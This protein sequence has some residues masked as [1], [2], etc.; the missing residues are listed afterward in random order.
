MLTVLAKEATIFT[1][2]RPSVGRNEV[3]NDYYARVISVWMDMGGQLKKTRNAM[4]AGG[5]QVPGGGDPW[6][7]PYQ[8][9]NFADT[10][11]KGAMRKD[12]FLV[13]INSYFDLYSIG[14]DGQSVPPLTAKVSKDDIIWANDGDY[15]G[16]ASQY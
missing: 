9:L 2:P 1:G 10:K 13:P 15:V 16:L 12:R 11:G 6:G 7:N 8:Y 5:P 14:K 4:V 3:R